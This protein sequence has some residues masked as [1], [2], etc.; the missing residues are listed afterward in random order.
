LQ[1]SLFDVADP[2]RPRRIQQARFGRRSSSE[3]ERDHHAFLYWPPAKL[4]VVP[5]HVPDRATS[6]YLAAG[7]RIDRRGIAYLG[8]VTHG[9]DQPILRSVVVDDSLFTISSRGVKENGVRAFGVR[10]WVSFEE[11]F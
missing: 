10:D 1:L 3:V 4:A 8:K 11:G 5:V 2:R 9:A 7:Y 6:L